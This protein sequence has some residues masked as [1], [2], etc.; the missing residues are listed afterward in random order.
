TGSVTSVAVTPD[1]TRAL[2]GSLDRTLIFW[3]LATGRTLRTLEGH[4]RPVSSV[5]VTP[6]GT[7]ALSGAEDRTVRVWDIT[8]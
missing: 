3:D 1:G 8:G 4:T 6:D 7:R 5:A 2:S